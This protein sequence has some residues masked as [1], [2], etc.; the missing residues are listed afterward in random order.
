M[1]LQNHLKGLN[2]ELLVCLNSLL[3]K[4]ECLAC[5]PQATLILFLP[6]TLS[7]LE[8]FWMHTCGYLSGLVQV[9]SL[10]SPEWWFFTLFP[11][12]KREV[13]GPE[14]EKLPGLGIRLRLF[15]QEF[16]GPR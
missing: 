7:C 4:A 13:Y 15:G 14:E 8:E 11:C 5:G 9:L 1:Y 16:Q 3:A 12:P 2:L 10:P 6:L